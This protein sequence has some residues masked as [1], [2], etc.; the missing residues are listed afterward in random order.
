MSESLTTSCT[1]LGSMFC[2]SIIAINVVRVLL[3]NLTAI[4]ALNAMSH[5]GSHEQYTRGDGIPVKRGYHS[6]SGR[7]PGLTKRNAHFIMNDLERFSALW[8]GRSHHDDTVLLSPAVWKTTQK[9]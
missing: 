7:T 6:D 2:G 9:N 1:V 3:P 4:F 8:S 5:D